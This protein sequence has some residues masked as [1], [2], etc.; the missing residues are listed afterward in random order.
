[1]EIYNITN[2]KDFTNKLF[3]GEIFDK[4]LCVD[5][6]FITHCSFTID[7]RK[8]APSQDE[9]EFETWEYIRPYAFSI[10]KGKELPKSFKIVLKLSR[11][12]ALSTL[13]SFDEAADPEA[14]F[15]INIRYDADG[16]HIITGT[17]TAS[18]D[19]GR[20]IDKGWDELVTKFLNK[21]EIAYEN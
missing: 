13:N 11:A 20:T 5:A 14:G 2:I 4:F 10:I 1:M 9:D 7:G 17:S 18:F 16:I 8:P 6:S 15:F 21:S 3:V 12:N 19:L